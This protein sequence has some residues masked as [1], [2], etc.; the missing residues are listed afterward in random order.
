MALAH[1]ADVGWHPLTQ[2]VEIHAK[3]A[4]YTG[5]A[6]AS[7]W[8][9]LPIIYSAITAWLLMRWLNAIFSIRQLSR[10]SR[11]CAS[12]VW[13]R[14]SVQIAQNLGLAPLPVRVH[15]DIGSPVLLGI[16]RPQVCIPEYLEFSAEPRVRQI[17]LHEFA[18]ARARD[19]LRIQI[20][21]LITC[22]TWFHPL[23]RR[24]RARF[25]DDMELACDDA[26][27]RAGGDARAYA[28]TLAHC[29]ERH[30][31]LI[32]S[33]IGMA[34]RRS[35]L[36]QRV[37]HILDTNPHPTTAGASWTTV[38]LLCGGLCLTSI[39]LAP[40]VL[41]DLVFDSPVAGTQARI[42]PPLRTAAP[43]RSLANDTN[44]ATRSAVIHR[45]VAS[46]NSAARIAKP[47]SLPVD[48]HRNSDTSDTQAPVDAGQIWQSAK[49]IAADDAQRYLAAQ[50]DRNLPAAPVDTRFD[51]GVNKS[52]QQ[53][54]ARRERI[55]N[56][57]VWPWLG[58]IPL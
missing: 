2:H 40:Q 18:H 12:A 48:E 10:K 3:E 13:S 37:V 26:V 7:S 27:L 50:S 38:T 41:V 32:V 4:V 28:E 25:R 44:P 6:A 19:A 43:Q 55:M 21:D 49:F 46:T 5:P 9:V 42:Q 14:Q 17:L 57:R 24:A 35:Q 47:I 23:V 36:M 34:E 15:P 22:L 16:W 11:S 33:P 30:R 31:Q 1:F 20:V 54:A 39:N 52:R 53:T 56:R 58:R 29:A 8:L 51:D 45:P